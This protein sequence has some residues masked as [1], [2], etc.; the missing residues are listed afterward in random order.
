MVSS[1][2]S[3]VV[4]LINPGQDP[5]LWVSLPHPNSHPTYELLEPVKGPALKNQSLS[6]CDFGQQQDI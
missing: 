1:S 3:P 5:W 4:G 6:I 2:S